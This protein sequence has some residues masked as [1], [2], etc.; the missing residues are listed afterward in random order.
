MKLLVLADLHDDFWTEAGRDPFAGCEDL[1]ED[2]GALILAGDIANKA[3]VRWKYAFERL[4]KRFDLG[5]TWVFPGNHDFYGFRVDEEERLAEIAAAFGIGY[6]QKT[7]IILGG[8][9]LLCAT[10][11]TDLSLGLGRAQNDFHIPRVMNDYRYIR[12]ASAG[13]RRI[14]PDDVVAIHRSHK[15][16]LE[17]ELAQPFDGK[18][19]VVT[20]HAPHPHVLQAY[21][22]GVDAAY[23]SDLGDLIE[24]GRPDLWLFGHCHDACDINV[25]GTALRNVSLGYP[26]DVPEPRERV[27]RGLLVL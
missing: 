4:G 18:T 27:A 11:W 14:K 22:E 9:R 10:L 21:A 1:L 15:A 16:W 20:H 17:N 8:C 3:P 6:A 24:Q 25:S 13:Y 2:V 19:I 26:A 12:K 7:S 23:A 5:K